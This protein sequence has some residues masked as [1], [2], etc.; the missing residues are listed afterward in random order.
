[1]P[2][3]KVPGYNFMKQAQ[4]FIQHDIGTDFNNPTRY[5]I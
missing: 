3:S 4:E 2:T 5:G 1:M